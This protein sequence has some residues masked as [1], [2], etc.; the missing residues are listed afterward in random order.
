MENHRKTSGPLAWLFGGST[1]LKVL[2][3]LLGALFYPTVLLVRT[4]DLS[5]SPGALF[6]IAL[7][8]VVLVLIAQAALTRGQQAAWQDIQRGVGWLLAGILAGAGLTALLA[9]SVGTAA[10]P[11]ES[12]FYAAILLVLLLAIGWVKHRRA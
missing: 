1:W 10:I 2:Y 8:V 12:A 11:W 5:L 7:A 9:P 4:G 6:G 3:L